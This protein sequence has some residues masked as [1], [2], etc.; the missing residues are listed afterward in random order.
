MT[1]QEKQE[2]YNK[3]LGK[4][5]NRVSYLKRWKNEAGLAEV[6]NLRKIIIKLSEE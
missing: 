1:K 6:Q 2:I 3:I 5:S 4:L